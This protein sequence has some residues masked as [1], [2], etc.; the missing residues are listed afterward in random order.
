MIKITNLVIIL[1]A[2]QFATAQELFSTSTIPPQLLENAN[3]VIRKN[4]V[5]ITIKD[6]DKVEIVTSRVITVIN[7]NGLR[8]IKA[9]CNLISLG[10]LVTFH[11]NLF[12]MP[13]QRTEIY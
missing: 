6:Y 12:I 9:D 1:I 3:A 8:D 13:E 5:L 2:T 10:S 7:K 11:I 4:D